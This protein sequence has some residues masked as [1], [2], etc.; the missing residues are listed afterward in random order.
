METNENE[1]T[2]VQNLWDTTKAVLREKYIPIQASLQRIEKSKMQFLYSHLKK[3]EHQQRDRPNPLTRKQLTKFRA[4]INQ[5]ENRSTV[6]QINRTRSWFI[7]RIHKIGRPMEDL[8]KSKE[9]GL[10]LLKL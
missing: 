5:L 2:T 8:Y 7:E 1:N 3:L 9:K 4:E 10:R 6:E